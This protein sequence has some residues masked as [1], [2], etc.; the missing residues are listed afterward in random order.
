MSSVSHKDLSA[1][2]LVHALDDP[3]MV[4]EVVPQSSEL[5]DP[6]QM[7]FVPVGGPVGFVP[8]SVLGK[9]RSWLSQ[10]TPNFLQIFGDGFW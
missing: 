4:P 6:I 5:S 1:N 2:L 8:E 3:F 9:K 7:A 10:I